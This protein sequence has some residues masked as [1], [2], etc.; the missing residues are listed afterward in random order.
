MTGKIFDVMFSAGYLQFLGAFLWGI[1]SV[2]LSPCGISIIPLVV[3]YV[4]NTDSPSRSRAFV[5]SCAFCLGI[6]INLLLVAFVMSGVGMILGGYERFLTLITAGIFIVMGL[7]LLGVIHVKFFSLGKSSTGTEGQ[8]LKGALL[9]GIASG[10]AIG[11]CTIAYVSPV[12]SLVMSGES[13]M[14]AVCYALGYCV[15]LVCAGT[16]AQLFTGFLQ[17][18]RGNLFL[19]AVNILCGIGLICGGVY[20]LSEM[21]FFL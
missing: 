19:R 6:V 18:E 9:L 21:R 15:V 4:A 2:L 10:L 12:L 1:A 20:F 16:F 13:V 14:L 5:I 11:P 3:G 8:D 7:H 17:D